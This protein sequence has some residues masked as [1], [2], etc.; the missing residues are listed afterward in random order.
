MLCY[1]KETRMGG[2][3]ACTYHLKW[4]LELRPNSLTYT[5]KHLLI[6]NKLALSEDD[7]QA[8]LA[9]DVFMSRCS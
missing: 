1:V 5:P 4:T 8:G 6:Y 2:A 9:G 7:K 3:R